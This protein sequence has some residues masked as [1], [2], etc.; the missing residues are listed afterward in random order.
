MGEVYKLEELKPQRKIWREKKE[1]VVF[2]NGVFD[3][4]H[5]GHVEYLNAARNFGVHLIVGINS[6]ESVRQIKGPLRPINC[7]DDR[8]FLISQLK[9]VD[10][11]AIFNETTPQNLISALLPDVLIKGGDW[12]L[13]EIIGKKEVEASGGKVC[14]IDFVPEKS[15]TSVIEKII[16]RFSK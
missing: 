1:I 7:E 10:A 11:V 13:E 9:C 8:A 12:K 2:T 3:I 15:T 5:R 14:T 4:L 6:D 16:E